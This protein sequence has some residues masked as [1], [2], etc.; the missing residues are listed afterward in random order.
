[1][2]SRVPARAGWSWSGTSD[3]GR[4]PVKRPNCGPRTKEECLRGQVGPGRAR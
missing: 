2:G 3:S 1:M 4:C